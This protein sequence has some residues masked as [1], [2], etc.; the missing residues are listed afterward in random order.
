MFW[1]L[2]YLFFSLS[3]IALLC[4]FLV[5]LIVVRKI[6]E[7]LE[8]LFSQDIREL[9]KKLEKLSRKYPNDDRARLVERVIK[10]ESFNAGVVGFFTGLG[11]LLT[12][13][14]AL[15]IDMLASIK[16]QS[17]LV[18]FLLH[19]ASASGELTEA[20]KLKVMAIVFGAGKVT[21]VGGKLALSLTTKY[22]PQVVL[23]SIP[24]LGGVVGFAMDYI[25]TRAVAK[26]V[27]RA[28]SPDKPPP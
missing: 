18:E 11:G 10:R 25:S 8:R 6:K 1:D 27:G 24:L 12:L 5:A 23:K 28:P 26:L 9:E 16:I 17:R 20:E 14:I 13:P 19:E 3:L 4:L 21:D 15:P 7:R 22:A 2:L